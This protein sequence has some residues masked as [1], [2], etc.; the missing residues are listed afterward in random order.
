MNKAK[1]K[2]NIKVA[3]KNAYISSLPENIRN[4]VVYDYE[5]DNL[6]SLGTIGDIVLESYDNNSNM[7]VKQTNAIID[8]MC[9]YILELRL[10]QGLLVNTPSG[11]GSTQ[12]SLIG[13]LVE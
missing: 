11:I 13:A 5:E 1:L 3:L 8:E 2:D 6:V 10:K 7:F 4:K 9:K 12:E